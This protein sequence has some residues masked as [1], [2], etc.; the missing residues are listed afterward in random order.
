MGK[1]QQSEKEAQEALELRERLGDRVQIAL[2]LNNLAAVC[3]KQHEF[4]KAKEFAQRAVAEFVANEQS[5][6]LIGY[7]A[8]VYP[9]TSAA[10]LHKSFTNVCLCR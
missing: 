9:D 8:D 6:L 2:S 4:E 7:G 10:A 5:D 1:I 3:I